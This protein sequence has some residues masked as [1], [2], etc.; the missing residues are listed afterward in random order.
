MTAAACLP[1][2]NTQL[3]PARPRS[4]NT[5][6]YYVLRTQRIPAVLVEC[7]FLSNAEEEQKLQ[8][9]DYQWAVAQSIHAG[10][11]E[12]LRV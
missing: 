5:G 6:D 9:D 10:L 12:Y 7:G 4:A 8:S 11:C 3:A 1:A 2:L